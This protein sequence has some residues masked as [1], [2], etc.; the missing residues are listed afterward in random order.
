MLISRKHPQRGTALPGTI[1]RGSSATR[2]LLANASFCTELYAC[3]VLE[4]ILGKGA[5]ILGNYVSTGVIGRDKLCHQRT[6]G[7]CHQRT[8]GGGQLFAQNQEV[9]MRYKVPASQ[10]H[11]DTQVDGEVDK[12]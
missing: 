5:V 3:S 6:V 10:I 11:L 1:G 4:Y 7:G 8:V 9:Q 2:A 12:A